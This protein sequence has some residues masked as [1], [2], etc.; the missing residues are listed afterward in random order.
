MVVRHCYLLF[1]FLLSRWISL[2]NKFYLHLEILVFEGVSFCQLITCH[3]FPLE[4]NI[5]DKTNHT[6][7]SS[8]AIQAAWDKT[9][10]LAS[11]R[12]NSD[13]TLI[14][15]YLALEQGKGSIFM[16]K[17]NHDACSSYLSSQNCQPKVAITFMSVA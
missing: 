9:F 11:H 1:P 14:T 13:I 17:H 6:L 2:Q 3:L 8:I 7:T 16:H 15:S 12:E 4:A 5:Q 10:W